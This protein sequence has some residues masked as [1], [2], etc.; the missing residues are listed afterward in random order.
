M[1]QQ[2]SKRVYSKTKRFVISCLVFLFI[3]VF[4]VP[5]VEADSLNQKQWELDQINQKIAEYQKQIDAKQSKINSLNS[6]IS[7]MN[8]QIAKLNLEIKATDLE[9]KQNGV[10]IKEV[11]EK[12]VTKQKE[13]KHQT[14]IVGR[15]IL[16]MYQQEQ[17][18][19]LEIILESNNF[20]HFLD[21]LTY[22]EI[23]E[24]QGQE[25]LDYLK[26]LKEELDKEKK[27]LVEAKK[28]LN[29]LKDKQIAQKQSLVSQKNTKNQ[30]LAK[31]RGEEA[32]Y[33]AMIQ[34]SYRQAAVVQAQIAEIIAR[35]TGSAPHGGY[36]TGGYPWHGQHGVDPWGFYMGQCT[37]YAAW[38]WSTLGRTVTWRGHARDW[39]SRAAAQGY[40]VDQ[41]P[42]SGNII[43]FLDLS[44]YGHV[45]I[46]ESVSG[47]QVTFTDY[48]G[49]GGSEEFGW[50][51]INYRSGQW[52][53][54]YF[55]H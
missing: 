31:T 10:K 30:L 55:I 20:S 44:Y 12:I 16:L 14:E 37:S 42:R 49:W 35:R 1:L 7:L 45:G 17:K 4:C 43:C 5:K 47:S 53:R 18:G 32:A 29:K 39:A 52:G 26:K 34:E 22:L 25:A 51:T 2:S 3:V 24:K 46:V 13:I 54:I 19:L 41:S 27:T 15:L 11:T 6:Q 40:R 33:Q 28:T 50:G 38:K 36:G 9:I 23:V 8:S 21:Q 48:N